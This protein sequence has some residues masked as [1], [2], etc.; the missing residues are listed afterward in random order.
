MS[1]AVRRQQVHRQ[2]KPS[3]HTML[4][5]LR[6]ALGTL[7]CVAAGALAAEAPAAKSPAPP[8]G[9]ETFDTPQQAGAALINAA[10]TFAETRPTNLVGQSGRAVILTGD[11]ENDRQR[12]AEFTKQAAK[13]NHVDIDPKSGTR[14]TVFVGEQDWPF[15]V[16][17]V[18][19]G[20][21]W[22]FDAV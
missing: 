12:A 19:L 3:A 1:A 5:V 7:V 9:V 10:A 4:D 17:V 20:D 15:P 21:K 14:A 18:K 13:K 16:P 6:I 22:F 2:S 11:G 8:S